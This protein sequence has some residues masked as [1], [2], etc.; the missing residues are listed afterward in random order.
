[1]KKIILLAV[2]AL[3][4]VS[5]KKD[6]DTEQPTSMV[7]ISFD[8]RIVSGNSM[9]RSATNDFLDIIEEQTP[10]VVTVTL[11]NTDLNKTYTC[12]SNESITIPVG[13]YEISATSAQPD[14]IG[15]STEYAFKT[16]TL[17]LDKT[18]IIVTYATQLIT[19][20]L[21]YNCF[22]IFALI[23]ECSACKF[24]DIYGSFYAFPKVGKYYVAYGIDQTRVH[25]EPYADSKDFVSAEYKFVLTYDAHNIFAEYGKYY[26][27]HPTKVEKSNSSFDVQFPT[28][29]EGEI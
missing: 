5:C 27:L 16:P 23:D 26:V 11:K 25:L 20:N 19:L 24:K 6:N 14:H 21:T 18:N 10:K 4:I 13:N 12:E 2:C 9:V 22:A 17:R 3:A 29:Q 7:T 15:S 8:Q 28:M 1:M